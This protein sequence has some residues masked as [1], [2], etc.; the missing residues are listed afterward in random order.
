MKI[1]I[2]EPCSEDW[3]NMT[4]TEQGA[5]CKKC[6]LEVTDFTDK[7]P[8]QIKE[9]L[10]AKMQSKER[11]CGHIENRQLI[12]FNN[13]F[14]PWTSDRESFRAI[15]TF[16]LIAVFGFT[17]FSC[18]STFSKEVVEKMQTSTEQLLE[19]EKDTLDIAKLND[20]IQLI[21]MGD[22]LAPF[23]GTPW[24]VIRP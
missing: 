20:S 2:P 24:E 22:S 16:S 10:T 19:E 18:Q 14:I 21:N 13:E 12:E 6:A 1:S 15:W 17:L 5:F 4:P 11:V 9:I 3:S 23:I 7:S 8:L